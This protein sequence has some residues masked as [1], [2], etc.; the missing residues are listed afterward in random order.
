DT[1]TRVELV[2]DVEPSAVVLAATT[3][4][5]V[6]AREDHGWLARPSLT[7][8][9]RLLL[10]C[11]AAPCLAGT[12]NPAGRESAGSEPAGSVPAGSEPPGSGPARPG[13]RAEAGRAGLALR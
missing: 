12:L 3:G 13:V 10:P 5:E 11:L 7:D 4:I 1:H 2:M 9:W 8:L 6:P